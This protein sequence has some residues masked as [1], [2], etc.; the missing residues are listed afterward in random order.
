MGPRPRGR[1]IDE[2]FSKIAGYLIASMGPR[3]RGRGIEHPVELPQF[4]G[5]L[6]WGHDRAVVEFC[7][8]SGGENVPLLASMG[9]RPRGRGIMPKPWR[10]LPASRL[11]WGHD[12]AV[13]ELLPGI[14]TFPSSVMLQWG[15]DRA[16]V[17]L[18]GPSVAAVC[19]GVAS[20][21]PRPRGR[22]IDGAVTCG[23]GQ[24]Y[25][26]MGPRPRGRGIGWS[27]RR[28]CMRWRC[29]NGATTARSWN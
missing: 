12:R 23:A 2:E 11:Q 17:E 6:Q 25:A 19:D 9:P 1:G 26:S 18:A 24:R 3:P 20:M 21:G 16:V 29:F 10:P 14:T 27:L 4:F 22:G 5:P 13:V 8:T 15:H 28:R 7:S